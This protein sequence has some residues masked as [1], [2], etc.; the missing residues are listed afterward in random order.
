M[1]SY[2]LK[3]LLPIK[4][5]MYN[6]WHSTSVGDSTEPLLEFKKKS[7]KPHEPTPDVSALLDVMDEL[8]VS[9]TDAKYGPDRPIARPL[10]QDEQE[11]R[12]GLF[13]AV[14]TFEQWK[15]TPNGP[16]L[17]SIQTLREQL[18]RLEQLQ[19]DGG[20]V[21]PDN[22]APDDGGVA[23]TQVE[24][25]DERYSFLPAE[26]PLTTLSK[27]EVT[28]AVARGFLV[29]K[30][31]EK[32]P[33]WQTLH[34]SVEASRRAL[35]AASTRDISEL[36]IEHGVKIIGL[37]E[38]IREAQ[39]V[40]YN[41][42][43]VAKL[44]FNLRRTPLTPDARK[45]E[46]TW[47]QWAAN[48]QRYP[49][50]PTTKEID[51][52]VTYTVYE[53]HKPLSAATEA[54]YERARREIVNTRDGTRMNAW[55]A[56]TPE[57]AAL[58][59]RLATEQAK[60]NTAMQ[61]G[62]SDF[63]AR[64]M[65]AK[66]RFARD[67]KEA[68]MLQKRQ[69]LALK[70]EAKNDIMYNEYMTGWKKR[71][72]D[73]QAALLKWTEHYNEWA[74]LFYH[75]NAKPGPRPSHPIMT[76]DEKRVLIKPWMD[77]HWVAHQNA[78]VAAEVQ[79]QQDM[80]LW[81][82]KYGKE[83]SAGIEEKR[84]Y[85][86]EYR[87]G[88]HEA[89]MR[90]DEEE[91]E[92][93]VE[94]WAAD[95][96]A[97]VA[98]YQ[99][100]HPQVKKSKTYNA[101]VGGKYQ[102]VYAV[103]NSGVPEKIVRRD[104]VEQN[105]DWEEGDDEEDKFQK[106]T[107][108]V[109]IG[110][111]QRVLDRVLINGSYVDVPVKT[112]FDPYEPGFT[113]EEKAVRQ[114]Q[115]DEALEKRSEER[116]QLLNRMAADDQMELLERQWKAQDDLLRVVYEP[117]AQSLNEIDYLWRAWC[118]DPD[119]ATPGFN[120]PEPKP[121]SAYIPR[122]V[123]SYRAIP[124]AKFRWSILPLYLEQ[125]TDQKRHRP[126]Q[127]FDP[128]TYDAAMAEHLVGNPTR[129]WNPVTRQPDEPP[130]EFDPSNPGLQYAHQLL[131]A[132]KLWIKY[133]KL[134]EPE[135]INGWTA[136]Q[137]RAKYHEAEEI[138]CSWESKPSDPR[139]FPDK[140]RKKYKKTWTKPAPG[141][142][143][144]AGVRA[145]C[146]FEKDARGNPI[147]VEVVEPERTRF[148]FGKRWVYYQWA[149]ETP[150]TGNS[151][152]WTMADRFLQTRYD[153]LL[154]VGT[155]KGFHSGKVF[156]WYFPST[157]QIQA[158]TDRANAAVDAAINLYNEMQ[159]ENLQDEQEMQDPSGLGD[160]NDDPVVGQA[161]DEA[162]AAAG[163]EAGQYYWPVAG[164]GKLLRKQRRMSR[165]R[166][167]LDDNGYIVKT[168][169]YNKSIVHPESTKLDP[170]YVPRF[171]WK[172][173]PLYDEK[174]CPVVFQTVVEEVTPMEDDPE[175]GYDFVA[176][177]NDADFHDFMDDDD[178]PDPYDEGGTILPRNMAMPVFRPSAYLD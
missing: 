178:N 112:F 96:T 63:K 149:I 133:R 125:R 147:L 40:E 135:E 129:L 25:D 172:R 117:P 123:A 115:L 64:R 71:I 30:P 100:K 121:V 23:R 174:D 66:E 21:T 3:P 72:A 1:T 126:V 108:L 15:A 83:I 151:E 170:R 24:R 8:T 106:K 111:N 20:L 37:K 171:T 4:G 148:D 32:L 162:A 91:L 143:G 114:N 41:I 76:D 142:N 95:D 161:A 2:G 92:A 34:D 31:W 157:K 93:F 128:L 141:Q 158:R 132:E 27:Q 175:R 134:I 173:A 145:N 169:D 48:P 168:S 53:P 120:I 102:F 154:K 167:E 107:I 118:K 18:R 78:E 159:A 38:E 136:D 156:S 130:P 138:E 7:A 99:E 86:F 61:A 73:Y 119:R 28:L 9:E 44:Q 65:L 116:K 163:P 75:P 43:V 42:K 104:I 140:Q 62:V 36:E 105:P 79:H 103:Q 98:K 70:E 56:E 84:K 54:D 46:Y 10:T 68:R 16:Y 59:Q 90:G 12:E 127:Y 22:R 39:D 35:K 165:M 131:G 122:R 60:Y 164:T 49:Y 94:S 33:V 146:V 74:F 144:K 47:R 26:Y 110:G 51:V 50:E 17:Q 137:I 77:E 166:I 124:N 67:Q 153:R 87:L 85:D 81:R 82:Q 58:Q 176:Q 80:K 6:S 89:E 69:E 113:E 155:L 109:R 139:A 14:R 13:A 52:D 19:T 57:I 150:S 160:P 97:R 11:K 45:L 55:D 152:F 88:Y 177:E 5:G 29:L 101:E